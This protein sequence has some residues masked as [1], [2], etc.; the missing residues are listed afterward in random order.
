MKAI[1][2]PV[3][4]GFAT[5]FVQ[6]PAQAETSAA[7][8]VQE[9]ET[10]LGAT[11]AQGVLLTYFAVNSLS[12]GFIAK[13]FT[14]EQAMTVLGVYEG[15]TNSVIETLTNLGKKVEFTGDDA[16]YFENLLELYGHL[17]NQIAA[18]KK[19][20]EADDATAGAEAFERNRQK[21]LEKINKMFG[22]Q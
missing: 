5:L 18:L 9:L 21:A 15:T 22:D 4:L 6:S 11:S 16:A 1:L 7:D 20:I 12:D 17:A 13:A 8:R 3:V 19:I 14:Q 2:L 10:A